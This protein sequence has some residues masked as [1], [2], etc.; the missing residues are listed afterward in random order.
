MN[1]TKLNLKLDRMQTVCE[2]AHEV[3]EQE[4]NLIENMRKAKNAAIRQ[5]SST[6]M[7]K[8]ERKIIFK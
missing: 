5:L 7:T 3:A 8:K 1:L 4:I 6:S 2:Q